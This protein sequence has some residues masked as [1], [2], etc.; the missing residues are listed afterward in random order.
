MADEGA[1]PRELLFESCRRNNPALLQTILSTLSAV[2]TAELI[3]NSR[4]GIGNY[5]LHVAAQY[6]SF[7]VLD[8]LLDQEDVEVDPVDRMEGDTPLHKAVRWAN[9]NW[10]ED[11]RQQREAGV[12][13]VEL[14][15]DAGADARVRNKGKLKAVE[16]VDPRNSVLRLV[17]QKAEYAILLG[18]GEEDDNM[19][20][21]GVGSGSDDG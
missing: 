9:A 20:Q 1:S 17:L 4:D 15:I 11:D 21:G 14:L 3:N 19:D 6:G 13:L 10:D 18:E 12:L 16:L 2:K 7:E 5:P 8:H